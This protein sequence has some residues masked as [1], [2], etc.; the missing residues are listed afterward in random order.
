MPMPVAAARKQTLTLLSTD[1]DRLTYLY[2]IDYQWTVC[3]EIHSSVTKISQSGARTAPPP[4]GP[5]ACPDHTGA[6]SIIGT[7]GNVNVH[8]R[9][10]CVIE[11]G[12]SAI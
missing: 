12:L 7:L 6:G 5:L 9:S 8:A 10:T 11:V 3:S 1:R 4:H 2:P